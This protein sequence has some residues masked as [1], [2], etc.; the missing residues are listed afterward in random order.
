MSEQKYF[1]WVAGEQRGQILFLDKIESEDGIT[2]LVFKDKSRINEA[3]VAEMNQKDLTGKMMAEIS[4]PSNGWKFK[5]EWVGREEEKWEQ[6]AEG[7]NVCVVPFTPGKKVVRLIPP[8]YSAARASS[9][10]PVSNPEPT[11]PAVDKSDPIYILMSKSRKIDTEIGM[12]MVVSLPPKPLYRLAKESF[13]EGDDK[14]VK[15]I[16]DEITTDEIKDALKIAV[17]EMYENEETGDA[18]LNI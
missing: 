10:G 17:K 7:E 3:F 2:Y 11:L 1:Q 18:S 9:F 12:G 14:F 16:V 8:A 13:E 4:G 15:Y 5:D 6:N